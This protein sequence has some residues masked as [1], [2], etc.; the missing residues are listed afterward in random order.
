MGQQIS[1]RIMPRIFKAI[2]SRDSVMA[3]DALEDIARK[4]AHARATNTKYSDPSAMQGFKRDQWADHE[5]LPS[6]KGQNEFYSNQSDE[7]KESAIKDMPDDLIQFLNDAGPLKKQI[8]KDFT[9]PKVYES[10]LE[11]DEQRK[12]QKQQ[13]SR[14][15]RRIM[16]M[17]GDDDDDDVN[18]NN[19]SGFGDGTITEEEAALGLEKKDGT[20]VSRTTNFSNA[21]TS[22]DD[23]EPQLRLDD[24][25][26]FRLLSDL[27]ADQ[28]TAD[29]YIES[30]TSTVTKENAKKISA[31]ASTSKSAL[32]K[33]QEQ[34]MED[35]LNLIRNMKEYSAIPVLMQDTDKTYVGA[36][37]DNLE[38]LK[39]MGVRIMAK[40]NVI[41]NLQ[42]NVNQKQVDERDEGASGNSSS[43]SRK[44]KIAKP[45]EQER[46]TD[47][48]KNMTT[49]EFLRQAKQRSN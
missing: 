29:Q 2:E 34:M 7:S 30:V 38:D 5:S 45:Y 20:M 40:D 42:N 27:Q 36:W 26:M 39:L 12:Q 33:E 28:M 47:E 4:Q 19:N 37:K 11:E 44:G 31:S 32:T 43:T 8:D 41:L 25:E 46:E 17:V 18:N 6:E 3:K 1:K 14:K 22:Q 21:R 10:L 15:T 9:S 13:D 24:E 35:N 16:P 48:K 49:A 23:N